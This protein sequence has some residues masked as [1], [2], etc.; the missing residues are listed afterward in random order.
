MIRL[1]VQFKSGDLFG[2][3]LEL[4]GEY[5][6]QNEAIQDGLSVFD[7]TVKSM[8]INKGNEWLRMFR[9]VNKKTQ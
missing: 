6:D 2:S 5:I 4:L 1:L 7:E 8:F 3:P 9:P